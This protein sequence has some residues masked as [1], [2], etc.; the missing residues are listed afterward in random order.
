MIEVVILGEKVH[1]FTAQLPA[2]VSAE[3]PCRCHWAG[4]CS[5][6][7]VHLEHNDL[8]YPRRHRSGLIALSLATAGDK[9]RADLTTSL[10]ASRLILTASLVWPSTAEHLVS[11]HVDLSAMSVDLVNAR[12][13]LEPSASSLATAAR[14]PR[15]VPDASQPL[16]DLVCSI[17]AER[18]GAQR[19]SSSRSGSPSRR[20]YSRHSVTSSS[21]AHTDVAYRPYEAPGSSSRALEPPP[22]PA[23]AR[24]TERLESDAPTSREAGACGSRSVSRPSSTYGGVSCHQYATDGLGAYASDPPFLHDAHGRRGIEGSYAHGHRA[25]AKVVAPI[26]LHL[27]LARGSSLARL[28]VRAGYARGRDRPDGSRP[29]SRSHSGSHA[30]L[31]ASLL[32]STRPRSH[33]TRSQVDEAAHTQRPRRGAQRATRRRSRALRRPARAVRSSRRPL[34]SSTARSHRGT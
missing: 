23:S 7:P 28:G 13:A 20:S 11:S 31:R 5:S 22:R 1:S 24:A 14:H 19:R 10:T 6:A 9:L 16:G 27:Q 18:P 8:P 15:E 34:A 2:E 12:L 29:S 3:Q 33:A 4:D 30:S 25:S 17:V 21:G 32:P 26:R